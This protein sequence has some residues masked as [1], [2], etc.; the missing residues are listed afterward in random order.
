MKERKNPPPRVDWIDGNCFLFAKFYLSYRVC[1]AR[2]LSTHIQFPCGEHLADARHVVEPEGI[3]PSSLKTLMMFST[4]LA[5]SFIYVESSSRRG[6]PEQFCNS[7]MKRSTTAMASIAACSCP[8][9]MVESISI[10]NSSRFYHPCGLA[11]HHGMVDCTPP[12]SELV[13][14]GFN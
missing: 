3:E 7:V 10:F 8:A 9:V 4:C 2:S 5:I 12:N 14:M 13:R 11:E 6:T 1:T